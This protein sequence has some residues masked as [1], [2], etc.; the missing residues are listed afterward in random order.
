MTESE[1]LL[2]EV[3]GRKII[4]MTAAEF[5]QWLSKKIDGVP[6]N[7]AD[8]VCL[9]MRVRSPLF[10]RLMPDSEKIDHIRRLK[11]LNIQIV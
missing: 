1:I 6:S 5:V 11:R 9:S 7:T 3:N 4:D 10:S 2:T 8:G